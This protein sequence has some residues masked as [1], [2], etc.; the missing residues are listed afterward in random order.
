MSSKFRESIRS[1]A[2]SQAPAATADY[3]VPLPWTSANRE[4]KLTP[5]R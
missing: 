3:D 4:S 1:L 2:D 5:E